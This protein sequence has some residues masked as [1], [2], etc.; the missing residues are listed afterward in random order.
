MA[1]ANDCET[2]V[3]ELLIDHYDPVY[4]QSMKRNFKNYV[5]SK[6]IAPKDHK[7]SSMIELACDLTL[8]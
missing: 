5:A 7:T 3:R 4:F 1:Q 8:E 6:L 2:V